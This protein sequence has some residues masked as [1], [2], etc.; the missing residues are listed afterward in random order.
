LDGFLSREPDVVLT[1]QHFGIS[2]LTF[3]RWHRRYDPLDLTSLE[4]RS[5]RP[6]RR[7]QPTWSFL[8]FSLK[9]K[10]FAVAVAVSALGQEQ[11][12]C[13]AEP[14]LRRERWRNR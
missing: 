2:R 5:H 8:L 7:R 12:C 14:S 6:R 9:R 1:C 13:S 11:D 10:G 4:A 3:Y